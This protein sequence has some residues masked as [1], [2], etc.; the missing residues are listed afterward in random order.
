MKVGLGALFFQAL[1][2]MFECELKQ[3][4]IMWPQPWSPQCWER[5]LLTDSHGLQAGADAFHSSVSLSL[6]SPSPRLIHFS[7]LL[8]ASNPAFPLSFLSAAIPSPLSMPYSAFAMHRSD[9][10][11]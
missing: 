1:S 5:G 6:L 7:T 3:A 11:S 8:L 9:H 2:V 4:F 10:P